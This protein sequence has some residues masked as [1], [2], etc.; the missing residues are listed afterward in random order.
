MS[1]YAMI[2]G[3]L[4][5]LIFFDNNPRH[6]N[7]QKFPI[8]ADQE[9]TMSSIFGGATA[10]EHRDNN[11][12]DESDTSEAAAAFSNMSLAAESPD[13][14][15]DGVDA[16][17]EVA[18]ASLHS[19]S[20]SKPLDSKQ[21]NTMPSLSGTAPT[22]EASK[23]L[24]V[25]SARERDSISSSSALASEAVHPSVP[26]QGASCS[27][28][29]QVLELSIDHPVPTWTTSVIQRPANVSS[30]DAWRV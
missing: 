11:N 13:A 14:P 1:D 25:V 15:F 21:E 24:S 10:S 8:K 26:K 5:C 3:L 18:S 20:L 2:F 28:N 12:K 7:S 6:C 29:A 23:V 16:S 27:N 19:C 4:S 30:V 17:S 22:S 9:A